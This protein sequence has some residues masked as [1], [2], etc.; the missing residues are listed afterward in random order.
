MAASYDKQQIPTRLPE[1]T[2]EVLSRNGVRL[3]LFGESAEGVRAPR[4]RQVARRRSNE[5]LRRVFEAITSPQPQPPL[6]LSS[7]E[8]GVE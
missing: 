2:L 7:R 3:R 8:I 6:P 1:T 4:D 5:I